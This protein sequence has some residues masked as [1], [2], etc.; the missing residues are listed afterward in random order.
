MHDAAQRL[1]AMLQQE[2]TNY[3]TEDYLATDFQR[4]L[5]V[6]NKDSDDD[7]SLSSASNNHSLALSS[8]SSLINEVWREKICEWSYQ[9]VDHFDYS[10]E[11]VSVS[12]N[13]L[14][15]F[16][17]TRRVN[18][19]SFQLAAMTCLFLAIKLYER[20]R[21]SM[22]SLIELSSGHFTV[23]QMEIMEKAILR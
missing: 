14:D 16:L 12:I 7:A 11:L 4:H 6:A 19:K 15:R 9:V 8:R 5:S 21:L 1:S 10:R 13:Y 20:R 18:K 2:L 17:S 23:L 3:K 22:A